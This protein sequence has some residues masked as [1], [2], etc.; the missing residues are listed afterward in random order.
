MWRVSRIAVHGGLYE[1]HTVQYSCIGWSPSFSFVLSPLRALSRSYCLFFPTAIVLPRRRGHR[2]G[3]RQY[4]RR[5]RN[6]ISLICATVVQFAPVALQFLSPRSCFPI[7]AA[8]SC[9][10]M[11][12]PPILA[13]GSCPPHAL[14]RKAVRV[15]PAVRNRLPWKPGPVHA[16]TSRRREKT[17]RRK[18]K[19]N[20]I[21]M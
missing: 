16:P 12:A 5:W 4:C 20:T 2:A 9:P 19:K 7:P 8:Y 3:R 1:S 21:E 11:P 10:P 17:T 6:V 14:P 13:R 18:T 15:S